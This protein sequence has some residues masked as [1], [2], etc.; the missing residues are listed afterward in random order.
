[1]KKLSIIEKV[2]GEMAMRELCEN[3]KKV[4][5]TTDPL[6]VAKCADGSFSIRGMNDADGLTFEQVQQMFLDIYEEC[7]V[8][9]EK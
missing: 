4:Y 6:T 2:N 3:A 1:M 5:D 7:Y 9:D 8:E